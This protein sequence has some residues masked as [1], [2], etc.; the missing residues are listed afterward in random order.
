MTDDHILYWNKHQL[1]IMRHYLIP[2]LIA[3]LIPS[4]STGQKVTVEMSPER[5]SEALNTNSEEVLPLLSA[6]GDRL[7][8]VRSSYYE[9]VGGGVY[10]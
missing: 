8:F 1:T 2:F 7:Y 10:Q 4:G 9:N 3:L 5:L 6:K